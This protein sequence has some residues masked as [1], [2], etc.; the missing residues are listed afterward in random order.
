MT[1]SLTIPSRIPWRPTGAL[2]AALLCGTMIGCAG[3]DR[4]TARPAA[5]PQQ[6]VELQPPAPIA[7]HDEPQPIP[8]TGYI[9]LP[10]AP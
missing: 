4:P 10:P 7:R 6:P 3:L 8:P 1:E 5:R 9:E 2:A